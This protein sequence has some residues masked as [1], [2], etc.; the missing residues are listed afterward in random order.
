MGRGVGEGDIVKT[1]R[2]ILCLS[3][4]T[5]ESRLALAMPGMITYSR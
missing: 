2:C 1:G 3:G 5:S 4:I